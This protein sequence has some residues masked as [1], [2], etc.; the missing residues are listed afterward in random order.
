MNPLQEQLRREAF[1]RAG[2]MKTLADRILS[3]EQCLSLLSKLEE[4][5]TETMNEAIS[6]AATWKRRALEKEK[7]TRALGEN[8]Q[9]Q[10][11]E[12]AK[13]H[14]ALKA[15]LLWHGAPTWSESEKATWEALTGNP[16]ATTKVL[17]D[18]IRSTLVNE[19]TLP[20]T[21]PITNLPH[22]HAKS[23]IH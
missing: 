20:Q 3:D 16:E 4:V 22:Q 21:Q 15:V 11:I 5:W 14:N 7:P 12:L 17:C 19:N 9:D 23:S 13:C 8:I 6:D 18:F 2:I 10:Q 1:A